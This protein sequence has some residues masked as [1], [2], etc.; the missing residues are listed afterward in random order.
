MLEIAN[1]LT[2]AGTAFLAFAMI[3][4][5]LLITDLLFAAWWAA[6]VTALSAIAFAWFWYGLALTRATTAD[7]AA[8]RA[9]SGSRA[10]SGR[11][12]AP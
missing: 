8:A 6:L 5:V 1:R 3:A 9:R 12:R 7:A 10:R 4:V 11:P 2:I